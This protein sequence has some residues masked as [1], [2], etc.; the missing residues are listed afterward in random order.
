[1]DDKSQAQAKGSQ[2]SRI[3]HIFGIGGIDGRKQRKAENLLSHGRTREG[4]K[5]QGRIQAFFA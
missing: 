5:E 2:G 1:M 4:K 3:K